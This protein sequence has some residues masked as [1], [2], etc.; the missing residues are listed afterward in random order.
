MHFA[1]G[2]CQRLG[3]YYRGF[4]ESY[5]V[6]TVGVDLSTFNPSVSPNE[7]IIKWKGN[8][9]L[10]GY[11]GNTKWYQGIDTVLFALSKLNKEN[12]GLFKLLIIPS[13]LEPSILKYIE[14]NNLKDLVYLPGKQLHEKIPSLLASADILT[15]VRPSDR[16]TEYSWPSKL[17][18]HLAL[19]KP[20]IVSRVGDVS[21]F[22]V[23]G[24]SGE[25]IPPSDVSA[26]CRVLVSL[27]DQNLRKKL[28]ESA[29]KLAKE[30]FEINSVGKEFY[31]FLLA[32]L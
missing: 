29:W 3:D 20:L 5:H 24:K 27:T 2:V 26:L 21:R 18:E 9:I 22:I 17:S 10:I 12:K 14:E 30:K 16:V 28:G 23:H 4:I 32:Q 13:S 15:I 31:N 7:D 6:F 19:G 1:V 11:A 8:S 25:I